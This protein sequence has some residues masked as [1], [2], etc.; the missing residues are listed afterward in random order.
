M[1]P[2]TTTLIV[3]KELAGNSPPQLNYLQELLS[4][5][6]S[7]IV[8]FWMALWCMTAVAAVTI[9]IRAYRQ[10]RSRSR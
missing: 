9:Y 3:L 10:H 1:D 8:A 4:P 6:L 5:Y 2:A 7:Q